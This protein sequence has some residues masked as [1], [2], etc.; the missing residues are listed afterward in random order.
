[1]M[2][3]SNV[4]LSIDKDEVVIENRSSENVYFILLT[5]VSIAYT[6]WR[7]FIKPF[8]TFIKT[9]AKTRIPYDRRNDPTKLILYYW[10]KSDD[11]DEDGVANQTRS[12]ELNL[13]P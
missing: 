1:M 9:K 6:D 10:F 5:D 8:S 11:T 7:P 2:S 3:D 12:I 4:Q 13:Q